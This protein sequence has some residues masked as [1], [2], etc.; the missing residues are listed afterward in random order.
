MDRDRVRLAL[1]GAGVI[2]QRHLKSIAVVERAELVAIVDTNPAVEQIAAESSV[3]F[4]RATGAMLKEVKPEGVFVC[5][6]TDLHLQPVLESLR[7]GAHV[8]VEKPITATLDEAE[9]IIE[10]SEKTS[11]H[12]LVGHHRRYYENVNETKKLIQNGALGKLLGLSGLWTDNKHDAYFEPEWR[13]V[14]AAGPVLINLIHE[15]DMLRYMCGEI[16][17]VSA[18]LQTGLRGHPKE[19][20]AAILLNFE[21]GTLGTFL[22]SDATPSPWTWEHATGDTPSYP[23]YGVN[24]LR[25]VGSEAALDFPNLRLWK[26]NGEIPDWQHEL[27]PQAIDIQLCNAFEAECAHFC[28]VIA[29]EQAPRITAADAAG[30]LA[31]VLAIFEAAD[32]GKEVE[33]GGA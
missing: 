8:L 32:S 21:N 7:S 13:K 6:P 27:T 19:E 31:V 12:V 11:R 10:L 24:V 18:K 20:T 29:G 23:H 26:H 33:I 25:F 5:S 30:S 9:E 28:E 15:I 3:P 14:R 4:F 2:G 16:V 17:S 22:I 1:I